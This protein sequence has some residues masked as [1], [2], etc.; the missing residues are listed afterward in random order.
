MK[1][2]NDE[3]GDPEAGPVGHDFVSVDDSWDVR[4]TGLGGRNRAT[5][6]QR[7]VEDVIKSRSHPYFGW[8]VFV[9]TFV[10]ITVALISKLPEIILSVHAALR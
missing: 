4:I 1:P 10:P 5:G 8:G 9:V 6:P 7:F 3:Q 2:T